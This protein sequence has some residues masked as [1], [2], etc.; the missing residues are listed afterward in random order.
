MNL[1]NLK[2]ALEENYSKE[3]QYANN[4]SFR[5][6]EAFRG[7]EFRV[8]CDKEYYR[9]VI[10]HMSKMINHPL[11]F[12]WSGVYKEHDLIK[13]VNPDPN[14]SGK[15]WYVHGE[16]VVSDGK[17]LVKYNDAFIEFEDLIM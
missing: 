4:M 8:E 2:E 15:D 14:K 6:G 7:S 12:H 5:H 13:F 1:E 17:W 10:E 11:Y 9:M 3:Y 16:V